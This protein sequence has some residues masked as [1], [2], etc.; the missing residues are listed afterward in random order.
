MILRKQEKP[1]G[2][3]H[4]P[5]LGDQFVNG[6]HFFFEGPVPQVLKMPNYKDAVRLSKFFSQV[7]AKQVARIVTL[8]NIS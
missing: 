3:F 6:A 1:K 8:S 4:W 5:E 7:V 2:A